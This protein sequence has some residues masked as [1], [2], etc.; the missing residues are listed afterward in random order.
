MWGRRVKRDPS[1]E[2]IRF[3]EK[4]LVPA[5]V[6]DARTGDVL[7]LAYMNRE[8]LE[9]TLSTGRAHYY[10]RSRKKLWLKGETSGNFQEVKA[11]YYDCDGDT[12]LLKVDQI[13]VA[14]HTGHRSCFF[15]PLKEGEERPSGSSIIDRV[16]QVIMDRKARMPEGSYVAQLFRGGL[17]GILAKV[18]EEAGELV[19]AARGDGDVVHEFADLLFHSL[20]LLG[21]RGVDIGEVYEE[22]ERRF[23]ISGIE[24]KRRRGKG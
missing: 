23:G 16:F 6:Q 20:V 1:L 18:E 24:E 8:A 4:G 15:S 9:R 21:Y 14:C 22:L 19:E 17:E 11:I 2:A 12:L 5:V 7:M 13:G 10:S 3:D